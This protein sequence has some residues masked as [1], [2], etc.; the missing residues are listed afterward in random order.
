MTISILN[1]AFNAWAKGDAEEAHI[2]AV[3]CIKTIQHVPPLLLLIA[4]WYEANRNPKPY[5]F[6]GITIPNR[7][8]LAGGFDKQA[9]MVPFIQALGFGFT[10]VGA[11]LP[12]PQYGNPRPRLFRLQEFEALINRFGFNSQGMREVSYNL[13][14]TVSRVRIP[15]FISPGKMKDTPNDRA[16][17]DYITVW[18]RLRSYGAICV[19][20][21]SSPN[22]PGLRDLQRKELLEGFITRLVEA[23]KTEASQLSEPPKPILIKFAPD[24]EEKELDE[25]AEA[26]VHGG[27]SGAVL[28]NTT[29]DRPFEHE[30]AKEVGGLSGEP[31][32]KKSREKFRYLRRKLPNM[33]MI[34]VGG[35]NSGMRARMMIEEGADL[36]ELMTG[37]IYQGPRLVLDARREIEGR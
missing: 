24:L 1:R 18:K 21:I 29:S 30:H 13:T 19:A 27:A 17:E 10:E 5:S 31:I 32:Y 15:V 36:V 25:I 9:E 26:L 28:G 12:E 16:V 37:F 3:R 33:P 20:N 22:T 11:I 8:G 14:T 4:W 2:L 23:E 35:I 6:C 34:Y 7:V